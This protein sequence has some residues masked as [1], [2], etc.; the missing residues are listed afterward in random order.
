[1]RMDAM[2]FNLSGGKE[3]RNNR[4]D[5]LTNHQ[6]GDVVTGCGSTRNTSSGRVRFEETYRQ[7]ARNNETASRKEDFNGNKYETRNSHCEEQGRDHCTKEVSSYGFVERETADDTDTIRRAQEEQASELIRKA[8]LEISDALQLSIASGLENTS[9]YSVSEETV[10]Q[11]AEII[12]ALKHI[13]SALQNAVA[14]NEEVDT[15]AMV[16]DSQNAGEMVKLL[17]SEMFKVDMG[18]QMLG[19]AEEVQTRVAQQMDLPFA[20]GLIQALNPAELSMPVEEVKQLFGD[21]VH[22]SGKEMELLAQKVR[23]LLA[24]NGSAKTASVQAIVDPKSA[25]AITPIDT[26]TYR[27]I[28]KLQEK[29]QVALQNSEAA[30]EKGDLAG[31]TPNL[32]ARS[33]SESSNTETELL[34]VMEL[35]GKTGGTQNTSSL[36][37]KM[38][39]VPKGLQESVMNQITEKL[40]GAVRSGMQEIRIQLKPET[41]GDVKMQIRVEGDVVIAKIQVESQQV[42]Q[43]VE[44]NL[45]SLKDS[46]AQHNLQAGAFEVNVGQ[47]WDRHSGGTGDGTSGSREHVSGGEDELDEKTVSTERSVSGSD[48]G[49]RYGNNTVEFIA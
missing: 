29:E 3:M 7:I 19:I 18:I 31:L 2:L 16:I 10:N 45:Q 38:T 36:E 23:E 42:K 24:E 20:G 41:L 40:H 32:I 27:A 15:G 47:G 30:K 33:I 39:G 34:S 28:F 12:H 49:R 21:L 48:T 44:S 46:L 43:I 11:F 1:M 9:F 8:L 25:D 22:E 5:R 4:M 26:Q 14:Q 17:R 6:M 13:I 37:V 35:N